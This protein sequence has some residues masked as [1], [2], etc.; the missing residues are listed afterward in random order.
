M[1][2][3]SGLISMSFKRSHWHTIGVLTPTEAYRWYE[4]T[5]KHNNINVYHT[6]KPRKR[7]LIFDPK[8]DSYE[9]D[10]RIR[11][12]SKLIFKYFL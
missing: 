8:C 1:T 12:V 6:S 10:T 4:S 2:R 5:S 3:H 9:N 7:L 11:S